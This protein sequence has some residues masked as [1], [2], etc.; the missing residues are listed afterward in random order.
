MPKKTSEKK[1]NAGSGAR[2]V[3]ADLQIHTPIDKRFKLPAGISVD[4]E[5]GKKHVGKLYVEAAQEKGLTVLGITEHNDLTFFPYIRDAAVGTDVI[6][7]P[8]V[9]FSVPPGLHIIALFEPTADLDVI[10]DCIV[11]MGLGK[12]FEAR[13]HSD[14]SPKQGDKVLRDAVKLIEAAGGVVIAPHVCGKSGLL[15]LPEG[16]N[17][18]ESWNEPKIL[19]AD[20]GGGRRVATLSK[21]ER[22]AFENTHDAYK[23]PY[24]IATVWTS[25]ARSLDDLGKCSTWIKLGSP[26]IEGLRQAFLDPGSRIRHVDDFAGAKYPRLLS[27]RWDG[28]G[29]LADQEILFNENLNCLIGGKGAGKSAVIE[30]IRFAFDIDPA[31][32]FKDQTR[33]LIKSVLPAGATVTVVMESGEPKT[34][35]SIT[36]PAGGYAPVVRDAAGEILADVQPA[37]L[38]VPS[39]YG[40]KEIYGIAQKRPDQLDVLDD[41]VGDIVGRLEVTESEY[42]KDLQKNGTALD[43]LADDIET[44]DERLKEL[45]RL[46]EMKKRYQALGITKKLNR[47]TTLAANVEKLKRVQKKL[48]LFAE[49]VKQGPAKL[50]SEYADL[51]KD[52]PLKDALDEARS[53]LIETTTE[54]DAARASAG[55]SATKRA[56]RISALVL[57]AQDEVEKED[58]AC[59]AIIAELEETYPDVELDDYLAVEEQIADLLPLREERREHDAGQKQ[60]MTQRKELLERLRQTRAQ[61]FKERRK[62]AESITTKLKDILR[63]KIE[64]QGDVDAVR[65]Y[66]ESLKM[67]MQRKAL[68]ALVGHPDFS[69]PALVAALEH[70]ADRLVQT[71]DV[72]EANAKR[73]VENIGRRERFALETFDLPDAISI[74]FNVAPAGDPQYRQLEQLSVGQ[75]STAILLLLLLNDDHPFIIDQPEDDLDNRF[76]YEDI[77]TRLRASKEQRQFIVATHNAN[78][79]VLGDAEQIVVLSATSDRTHVECAGSIDDPAVQESVKHILEGGPQAFEMRRKKYGF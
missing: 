9:E 30:S 8:G 40:Q 31:A 53:L 64:F 51:P 12:K 32:E 16:Q 23:R 72:S 66:L 63:I 49:T 20:P 26:T 24:P 29:F 10:G 34:T 17:R 59:E 55:A 71:F 50:A 70:G 76:I 1:M 45:P 39:I 68:D 38:P 3:R 79:P 27:I 52:E 5:D 22:A 43:G 19:A 54:W 47:K 57:A 11:K 62:T 74:E 21:F 58:K 78:I 56:A 65:S 46:Q 35:Y 2:F 13:F 6:V 41:F 25:D 69:V 75:K 33:S 73:I 61:R 67:G 48:L 42:L 28:A 77:V 44:I 60:L 36:R 7:F 15:D 14:G 4:T 37:D 18:I